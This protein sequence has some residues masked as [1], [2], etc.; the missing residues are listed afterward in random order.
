L[1]GVGLLTPSSGQIE[2][3]GEV[4]RPA[5]NKTPSGWTRKKGEVKRPAPNKTPSGWTRKRG[6]VGRPAPNKTKMGKF[7]F[8]A[9]LLTPP[10]G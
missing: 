4:G 2:K 1:F 8:G 9:G 5:P 7:V 10:S 6:E 3:M